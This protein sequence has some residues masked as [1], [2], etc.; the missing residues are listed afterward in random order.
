MGFI[1]NIKAKRE[2]KDAQAVY[3]HKHSRWVQDTEIFAKISEA[4]SDAAKGEDA[5]ENFL[6]NKP[7]ECVLWHGQGTLHE[8][9]RSPGQYVGSSSGFS[10]PVVA[11]V[12]YRVG[13]MR[14]TFVPGSESQVYKET[15]EV[16]LTTTRVLFN[17]SSN[18]KEWDFAKW[19]G[20]STNADE[21]DLSLIHI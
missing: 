9:G 14:G 3:E 18:T 20:A 17:G 7:G 6:V 8:T 21:S 4:F 15:G 12:R 16:F 5:V 1:A 13:A 2:A 19:T 10:I 11:G